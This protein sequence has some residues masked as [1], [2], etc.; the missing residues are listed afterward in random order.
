MTNKLY[1]REKIVNYLHSGPLGGHIDGF[2]V[3]LSEEGYSPNVLK[4]KIKAVGVW[5]NL[6]SQQE[7]DLPTLDER[8]IDEFLDHCRLG[9]QLKGRQTAALRQFLNYLRKVGV[10]FA[11]VQTDVDKRQPI[12]RVFSDYLTYERGIS[13]ATIR[14]K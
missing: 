10:L 6:L 9:W 8:Y 14:C 3:A 7:I 1:S 13:V 4:A 11:A 2:A 5:G 12:E